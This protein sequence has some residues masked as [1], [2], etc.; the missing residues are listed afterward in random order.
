MASSIYIPS[1]QPE[2]DKHFPIVLQRELKLNDRSILQKRKKYF[3]NHFIKNLE[4]LIY[5]ILII[6]YSNNLSL[7]EL[8]LQSILQIILSKPFPRDLLQNRQQASLSF[9]V[10]RLISKSILQFLIFFN[11]V[12]ILYHLF[13]F[14]QPPPSVS[15]GGNYLSGGFTLQIIGEKVFKNYYKFKCFILFNDFLILALQ[16]FLYCITCINNEKLIEAGNED[17]NSRSTQEVEHRLGGEP[18]EGKFNDNDDEYDGYCGNALIFEINPKE[19]YQR[20]KS[21]QRDDASNNNSSNINSSTM[22]S[23]TNSS[24]PTAGGTMPGGFQSF[25][26][27]SFNVDDFV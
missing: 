19:M 4:V 3:N 20:I 15:N 5:S 7:F 2:E 16:Y 23:S 17:N 9:D 1:S 6:N 22:N 24:A 11:A 27:R 13:L 14:K 18:V 8:I 25:A 26:S 12:K 21:F 10:K